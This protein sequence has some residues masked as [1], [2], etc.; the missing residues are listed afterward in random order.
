[1]DLEWRLSVVSRNPTTESLQA[2]PGLSSCTETLLAVGVKD[3]ITYFP[4]ILSERKP[5]ALALKGKHR[6][7]VRLL[8]EHK[9]K[10]DYECRDFLA[11]FDQDML[12]MCFSA[13]AE[14]GYEVMFGMHFWHYQILPL[15][16]ELDGVSSDS[17]NSLNRTNFFRGIDLVHRVLRCVCEY[18]FD[19][20]L[21][22]TKAKG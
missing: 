21:T 15:A 12:E 19:L 6:Q 20:P 2:L 8:V 16:L 14:V 13:L 3:A 1:M 17:I 22:S 18:G 7:V 4:R 9:H 10:I 11:S 5:L